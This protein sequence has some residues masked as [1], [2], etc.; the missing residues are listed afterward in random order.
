MYQV[1]QKGE[2]TATWEM[3][4]VGQEGNGWWV[5]TRM[6]IPEEVISKILMTDGGVERFVVKA[7]SQPAMELPAVQAQGVPQTGVEKTGALVGR[8]S[9]T[10][11]AGTFLCE[12]YRVQDGGGASDIWVTEAVSPYGVVKMVGPEI[13]LTLAKTLTG[14]TTRIRETPQKIAM[15]AM[16]DVSKMLGSD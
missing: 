6:N 4:V 9:V 5:E 3:A 13:T 12:H 11:P 2:P 8:E 15:P 14:A 7:A 16:G 10:T 1:Q